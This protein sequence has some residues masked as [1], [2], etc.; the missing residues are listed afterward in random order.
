[1]QD[2]S[3]ARTICRDICM[4]EPPSDMVLGAGTTM[5]VIARTSLHVTVILNNCGTF[6]AKAVRKANALRRGMREMAETKGMSEHCGE[7]LKES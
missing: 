7:I 3:D 4:S 6:G 1:M 2:P 5:N